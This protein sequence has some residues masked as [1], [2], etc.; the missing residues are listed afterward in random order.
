M[1]DGPWVEQARFSSVGLP[2]GVG[3]LAVRVDR[4][5]R[6]SAMFCR[7]NLGANMMLWIWGSLYLVRGWVSCRSLTT[8]EVGKFRGLVGSQVHKW[9]P[10]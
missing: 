5:V 4:V 7:M 1:M 8:L 6:M 10:K 3:A 9:T 2:S